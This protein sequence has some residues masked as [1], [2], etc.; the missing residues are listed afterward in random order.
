MA[1]KFMLL[2]VTANAAVIVVTVAAITD[3]QA[4]CPAANN[5]PIVAQPALAN[6]L[7]HDIK[8]WTL[9]S[10]YCCLHH[11]THTLSSIRVRTGVTIAATVT[12]IVLAVICVNVTVTTVDLTVTVATTAKSWLRSNMHLAMLL[13]DKPLYA[14]LRHYDELAAMLWSVHHDY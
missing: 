5:R 11:Y 12:A 9:L 8:A 10:S 2:V 6:A 14:Q 1:K 7:L 13:A 3:H 4:A